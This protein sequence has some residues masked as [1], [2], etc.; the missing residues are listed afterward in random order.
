MS[1]RARE[2]AYNRLLGHRQLHEQDA[3]KSD[4][5]AVIESFLGALKAD[6]YKL[7]RREASDEMCKAGILSGSW[8]NG[9]F[10]VSD[11]TVELG[12]SAMWDA[13]PEAGQ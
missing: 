5:D 11:A 10:N 2:A 1:E 7:V 8:E 12:W 6:G 9:E 3:A 4:A 13:A